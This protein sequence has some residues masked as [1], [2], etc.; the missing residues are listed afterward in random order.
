MGL[1]EGFFQLTAA[2]RMNSGHYFYA[3]DEI[4]IIDKTAGRLLDFA[5]HW[6]EEGCGEPDWCDGQDVNADTVV[7]FEDFASIQF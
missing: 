5:T 3:N 1:P 6:L 7:N 4:Q 2:G